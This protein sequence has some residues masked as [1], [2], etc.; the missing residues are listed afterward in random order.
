MYLQMQFLGLHIRTN[1]FVLFTFY[2]PKLL[3]K[4]IG[5]TGTSLVLPGPEIVLG[6]CKWCL[7]TL[8]IYK[9][10][11]LFLS[12]NQFILLSLFPKRV[13]DRQ[14][15]QQT[16]RPIRLVIEATFRRLIRGKIFIISKLLP[17]SAPTCQLQPSFRR[18]W[19]L[20][21]NCNLQPTTDPDRPTKSTSISFI[22]FSGKIL[23]LLTLPSEQ[24][25]EI[26]IDR[27]LIRNTN[28]YTM[29]L[30]VSKANQS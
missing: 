28:H 20:S 26:W 4:F 10:N 19:A 6:I 1:K 14:T 9:D 29:T 7:R 27:Q 21:Y 11:F 15:D 24:S 3:L 22:W 8:L 2:Q 12:L 30:S 5:P 13:D 25:L 23:D 17:S 18:S 16:D